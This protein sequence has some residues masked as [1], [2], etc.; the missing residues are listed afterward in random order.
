MQAAGEDALG[1][2]IED[3]LEKALTNNIGKRDEAYELNG[4]GP[5]IVKFLDSQRSYLV[6]ENGNVSEYVDISK[7]VK[8]GELVNYNP[9][10]LD[11]KGTPVEASKLTYT[12][13]KG[14]GK[15]HGNGKENQTFKATTGTK[16]RILNIE[17]GKVELISEN[18]IQTIENKNFTLYGATGYLYAEQELNEICKIYGYGYGADKT[19]V[20]NYTYGGPKDGELRGR[21]T[22]SGARSIAVE[23][24]N[25]FS[26][27]D[28][29]EEFKA[30]DSNYGSTTNPPMNIYYPTINNTSGS[31]TSPG[32]KNLMHTYYYYDQDK[33]GENDRLK[34]VL[35][36]SGY[37]LASRCIKSTA[38]GSEFNVRV[39]NTNVV[40]ADLLCD[41]KDSDFYE[42]TFSYYSVRPIVIID[43]NAI[44]IDAGYDEITGWELK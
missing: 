4:T 18:P 1:Q 5:F 37:W 12:S 17:Y 43:A 16:W 13:P 44:D 2:I 23:D 3:N 27:I 29:S 7:Y 14:D 42:Y 22:G 19:Q 20:I 10:I 30:L 11:K 35:F 26:G 24:I 34:N 40:G 28:T 32:I 9:T 15:N 33:L 8:V 38:S 25:R 39:V 31:S 36:N 21:I 41:G 6:D